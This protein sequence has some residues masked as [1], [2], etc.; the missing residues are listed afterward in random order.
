MSVERE[1]RGHVAPRDDVQP[2]LINPVPALPVDDV[3]ARLAEAQETLRAIRN[4]EVDALVVRDATHDTQVFTLSS[5]DRPYRMFVENMRDGAA[6][7]SEAGIILYAN[8]RLAELLA[9]PLQQVMGAPMGSFIDAG[10]HVALRS[11][12]SGAEAGGTIE[13]ELLVHGGSLLP[14]RINTSSLDVDLERLLCITFAD[15]SEQNGQKREIDRLVQAQA[16]RMKELERAQISL[17]RLATHDTLTGLP[18]RTLLIDRLNQTL[19]LGERSGRSAGIIFVDLDNFKAINDTGGHAAGDAVLREVSAR[20]AA[21]IRPMDT[22]SRLGGDEFVVLLADLEG[23]SDAIVVGRRIVDVINTPI[24]F[25]R[26]TA[27]LTAS[28]G[29][30]VSTHNAGYDADQLLL[31]ADTAM[32][33]AKSFGGSRTEIFDSALT[34]ISLERDRE[35]WVPR[36]R[37]ALDHGRFVLHGQPIVDLST[38]TILQHELLLRMRDRDDSL[39]APL[40]FLPAAE[41]SGLIKQIDRWVIAQ[42]VQIAATG[43]KVDVNLSAASIGDSLVL[44]LIEHELDRHRADPANVVFE[45]TETAAM[46]NLDRAQQCAERLVALGCGLALDDF[47]T[48]FASFTYLARLPFRYLKIDI[49]FV[50]NLARNPHHRSIVKAIVALAGDFGQQTIAEGVEDERTADIL[51]DLGVT[52]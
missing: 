27:N 30:A 5:A 21:A 18:N 41:R 1:R 19:A 9:R 36:I 23:P 22:V 52:W 2:R 14:V 50:R 24:E 42:A 51:R 28:I 46:Q 20:L 45:I 15:L 29:I 11:I 44:E 48:G 34:P 26:T 4:G 25:Q 38:G 31:E 43:A 10:D 8:R 17:T 39:I 40:T 3:H 6:T 49:E 13:A 32:Y 7:V 12:S 47:G 33:H 35:P 37:D 16:E